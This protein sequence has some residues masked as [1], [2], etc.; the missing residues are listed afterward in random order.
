MNKV[1]KLLEDVCRVMEEIKTNFHELSGLISKYDLAEQD[2]LHHIEKD[3]LSSE[4]C[5][6]MVR[7]MKSI[8]QS[9]R[10]TKNQFELINIVKDAFIDSSKWDKIK[11]T[12]NKLR[13]EQDKRDYNYRVLSFIP[14]SN[15]SNSTNSQNTLN[16]DNQQA[17]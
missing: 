8:R 17:S 13:A 5:I 10:F 2:I 1:T 4:E 3:D 14:K 16:L 11:K 9:R 7:I 15:N 12:L 6:S